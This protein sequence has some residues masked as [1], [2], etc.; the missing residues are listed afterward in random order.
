MNYKFFKKQIESL[1]P[2]VK[3]FAFSLTRSVDNGQDLAQQ[4]LA[5]CLSKHEQFRD[6]LNLKSWIFRI[7]YTTW[8]DI[9]RKNKT[10]NNYRSMVQ[11]NSLLNDTTQNNMQDLNICID[12]KKLLGLLG[13]KHKACFH[14]ICIEGY[15]YSEAARI[16]GIPVGTVASRIAHARRQFSQYFSSTGPQKIT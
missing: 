4:A 8:I 15:S 9:N 16:L 6:N 12:Y 1:I 5:I 10:I 11:E 14:L 7:V 2:D 13:E 3:R